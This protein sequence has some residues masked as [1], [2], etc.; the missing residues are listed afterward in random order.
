[1][2][3][4]LFAVPKPAGFLAHWPRARPPFRWLRAQRARLPRRLRAGH[5]PAAGSRRRR[6]RI[7]A[8]REP[9]GG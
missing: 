6:T 3:V 9:R 7:R 2:A 5:Q 4:L 1:M 8:R